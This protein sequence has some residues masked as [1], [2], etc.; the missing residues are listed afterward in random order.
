MSIMKHSEEII[1]VGGGPAGAYCALKLAKKGFK[2]TILDHSHPRE[3]P[4]GGGISP[5]VLKKFP[6]LEKFRS[7]GF[8]FGNF[9]IITCIDTQVRTKSLENGFCISRKYLDQGI[10]EMATQNG[11]KIIPEKVLDIQKRKK[12]WYVLTNKSTFS[13]KILVGADGVNSIVRRKT[14]GP[15]S[16]EN[17]ALT[18]GYLTDSLETDDAT[19]KFLAEIPGYI[20]V[21]P[22]KGYSNIGIGS[23]IKHGNIFKTLLD[24]FINY[25]FPKINIFSKYAAMIPSA[26][27]ANFFK[28]PCSGANW[29]LIG[30][31]AGHVDPISGGGILY[32]L[33]GGELAAEA[34]ESNNLESFNKTWK[35]AY[36]RFFEER[37][38]NKESYYNPVKS[39]LAILV[40]LHKNNY[41][42][43]P[44]TT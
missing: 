26:S 30:D 43:P 40:G 20:W 5:P 19:I 31:A 44:N 25:N 33:W 35:K 9:R 32:A 29:V 13:T 37:C 7:K 2:P 23:G 3:K 6:F 36:G 8:T 34:I 17:L 28:L 41:F 14:V 18:F 42:F 27:D 1:I 38:K 22:G 24:A 12:C 39:T 21:F 4:C 16:R 11:A 10:L 15:I